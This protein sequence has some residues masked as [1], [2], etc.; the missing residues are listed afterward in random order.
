MVGY[1]HSCS[2]KIKWKQS[3]HYSPSLDIFKN[4]FKLMKNSVIMFCLTFSRKKVKYQ[5]RATI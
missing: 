2:C 3:L 4:I 5:H 1:N